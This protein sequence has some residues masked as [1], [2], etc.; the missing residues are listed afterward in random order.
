MMYY[1]GLRSTSTTT[2]VDRA[3]VRPSYHLRIFDDVSKREILAGGQ[4]LHA[5]KS[6]FC[7]DCVPGG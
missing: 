1:V 5:N 2:T 3:T 6:L 4:N 7:V